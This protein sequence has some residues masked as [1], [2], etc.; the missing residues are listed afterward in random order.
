MTIFQNSPGGT[1]SATNIGCRVGWS[2]YTV[3][4]ELEV[5]VTTTGKSFVELVPKKGSAKLCIGTASAT[6]ATTAVASTTV[7][8]APAATHTATPDPTSD[9]STVWIAGAVI[10]PIV[11]LA[12][13]FL[14]YWLWRRQQKRSRMSHLSEP[15]QS[16]FAELHGHQ[17]TP[18]ELPSTEVK[19]WA[20]LAELPAS[21][22]RSELPTK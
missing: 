11:G 14:A 9:S 21:D 8:S 16:S 12:L 18:F 3:Y 19:A 10:G 5:L 4:R 7:T 1:P 15:S 13:V 20:R 17:S 2:A 6:T 22:F